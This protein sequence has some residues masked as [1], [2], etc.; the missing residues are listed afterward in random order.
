MEAS[1]RSEIHATFLFSDLAGF[2]ALTEAHGDRDA[3]TTAERFFSL[4]TE[5]LT[6]DAR[7]VKTLG[8]AVMVVASGP[9][10]GLATALRIGS[11]VASE[12]H[13]PELRSGLHHGPAI[14]RGGDYFGGTVNLASRLCTQARPGHI[15]CTAEVAAVASR[16]DRLPLPLGPI[17][18]KNV[19]HAVELFE[20]AP[21]LGARP[22]H[23]DPVCRMRVQ[24]DSA[25]VEI[26]HEGRR[27]LFCS[28]ACAASFRSEPSAYA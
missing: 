16:L 22:P 14:A 1:D 23:V 10:S 8:D 3:V 2:T 4:A 24:S 7:I 18:L 21:D 20:I 9:L 19:V 6:G 28:A 12:P 26:V 27:H 25:V 11:F 15:V 13:F 17:H 5:A